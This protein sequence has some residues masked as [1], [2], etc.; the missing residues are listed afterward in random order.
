MRYLVY[1]DSRASTGQRPSNCFFS[2]NQP[3]VNG[4]RVRVVSFSFANTLFNVD[5]SNNTLVFSTFTL[6]IPVGNYT[7]QNLVDVINQGCLANSAFTG[8]APNPP[9]VP[10]IQWHEITQTVQFTIGSNV[11]YPSSAFAIFQ[12]DPN[13]AAG[14]FENFS[15]NI[16][17]A[18]PWAIA[19]NSP[20]LVGNETRF[21]S[22]NRISTPFYVQH[23]ESGWGEVE[24][25]NNSLQM[26]YSATLSHANI[27]QLN[28]VVT[29]PYSNRELEEISAW[30]CLLE[31][32][33]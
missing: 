2:L 13:N 11:L 26:N 14:Y 16:F 10:C 5:S 6:T 19:L 33:V 1:L 30:S 32:V 29:D 20:S 17:L 7:M 4:S 27:N 31:I 15:C 3:I 18:S 23:I 28:V 8:V 21:V 24:T 22:C 25:A 12:L 9:A